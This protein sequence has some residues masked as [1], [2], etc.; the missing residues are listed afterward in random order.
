MRA[1]QRDTIIIEPRTLSYGTCVSRTLQV[2]LPRTHNTSKANWLQVNRVLTATK[3]SDY[4]KLHRHHFEM[5]LYA[6]ATL[7]ADMPV[8]RY[9]YLKSSS[10]PS[11]C[12]VRRGSTRPGT[13][14]QAALGQRGGRNRIRIRPPDKVTWKSAGS[15]GHGSSTPTGARGTGSHVADKARPGVVAEVTRGSASPRAS[16]D[17]PY[18][19]GVAVWPVAAGAAAPFHPTPTARVDKIAASVSVTRRE[20]PGRRAAGRG[21]MFSSFCFPLLAMPQARQSG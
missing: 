3:C 6:Y 16:Q 20:G 2:L 13:C 14:G 5:I 7:P 4:C 18:S 9:C 17:Y 21:C 12:H 11:R 10:T 15:R 19:T 8:Q 1:F